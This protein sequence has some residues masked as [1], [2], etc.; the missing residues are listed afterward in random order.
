M[1]TLTYDAE[2]VGLADF[3][4]SRYLTLV[5]TAVSDLWRT[6]FQGPLVAPVAVQRLKSLVVRVREYPHCEDVQVSL[7]Y[8]RHLKKYDK[9][10][11]FAVQ[12]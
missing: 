3:R 8:P 5:S 12:S 11:H 1:Q 4:L 6:D 7:S 10:H 9:S 2:I